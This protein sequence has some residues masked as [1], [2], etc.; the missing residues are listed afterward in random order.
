MSERVLSFPETLAT[1]L[2]HAAL[3]AQ[4]RTPQ[5]EAVPLAQAVGRTL[6]EAVLADRDQPPFARSTRDGYAVRAADISGE[7]TP[8]N[9]GPAKHLGR[10][11]PSRS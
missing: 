1:V 2:K 9:R 4:G 8:V 6:C 11:R 10:A 3:A 5:P 7:L